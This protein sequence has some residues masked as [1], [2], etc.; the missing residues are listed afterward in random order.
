MTVCDSDVVFSTFL[1]I[2]GMS[3]TCIQRRIIGNV[4]IQ[5]LQTFF[6]LSRFNVF[7][8]HSHLKIEQ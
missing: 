3:D 1:G 6:F 2:I 5:C 8:H 7:R 4:F